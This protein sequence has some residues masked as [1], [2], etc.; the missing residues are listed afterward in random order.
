VCGELAGEPL[1]AILL[2]AM[3][4]DKLSMNHASLGKINF[5]L[6]RVNKQELVALLDGVLSLSNGQQVRNKLNEFLNAN[7]LSQFID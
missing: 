3:G 5:L 4:Y 2:V 6:R 1:G 7:D